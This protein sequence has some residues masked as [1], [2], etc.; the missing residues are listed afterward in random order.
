MPHRVS[1][2]KSDEGLSRELWS[3]DKMRIAA[4]TSSVRVKRQE[5]PPVSYT[6]QLKRQSGYHKASVSSSSESKDV[7]HALS[8]PHTMRR[9]VAY[10]YVPPSWSSLEQAITH[11]IRD[12]ENCQ[13]RGSSNPQGVRKHPTIAGISADD[14]N[15]LEEPE[16][17]TTSYK[18]R[19]GAVVEA[20]FTQSNQD[21]EGDR[22]QS[23]TP[24]ADTLILEKIQDER[25]AEENW[26]LIRAALQVDI[27]NNTPVLS[28]RTA[29]GPSKIW[30]HSGSNFFP[31]GVQDSDQEAVVKRVQYS[32][33]KV[34]DV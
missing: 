25:R 23:G 16:A 29:H 19:Q 17:L 27:D 8:Q 30:R 13:E 32:T 21:F 10:S 28:S 1:T 12:V 34:I 31:A 7:T 26:R 11:A 5:R 4:R 15:W 33:G 14:I 24:V 9:S 3:I 18:G 22:L 2:W 6:Q 20:S